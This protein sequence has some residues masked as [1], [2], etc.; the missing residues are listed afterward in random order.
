MAIIN[1]T[2]SQQIF[3]LWVVHKRNI[4]VTKMGCSCKD[5]KKI[6]EVYNLKPN[7]LPILER[8]WYYIKKSLLLLLIIV[9]ALIMIPIILTVL[10]YSYAKNGKAE[11]GF[12]YEKLSKLLR[13]NEKELQNTYE[14]N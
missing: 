7:E 8:I 3:S 13:V 2:R 10:I 5:K 6:E 11:V 1:E 14:H 4:K 12:P 9:L